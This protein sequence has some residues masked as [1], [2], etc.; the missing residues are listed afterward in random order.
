MGIKLIE[1]MVVPLKIAD[2][3]LETDRGSIAVVKV[4]AKVHP[5]SMSLEHGD[6]H[7][8]ESTLEQRLGRPYAGKVRQTGKGKTEQNRSKTHC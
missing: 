1:D 5:V 4:D 6:R 8:A 3:R 7:T 2:G